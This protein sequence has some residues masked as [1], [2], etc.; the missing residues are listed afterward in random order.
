MCIRDSIL[1]GAIKEIR[2]LRE[3][4]ARMKAENERVDELLKLIMA[5]QGQQGQGAAV[6]AA[7]AAAKRSVPKASQAPAAHHPWAPMHGLLHS[8]AAAGAQVEAEL[9]QHRDFLPLW[10]DPSEYNEDF[11]NALHPPMA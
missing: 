2:A 3:E 6:A 4:G 1:R 10:L 8:K 7:A 5:D 9:V 11:D